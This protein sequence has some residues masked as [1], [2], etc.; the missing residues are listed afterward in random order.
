MAV[1]LVRTL[2]LRCTSNADEAAFT[3]LRD[4]ARLEVEP[5]RVIGGQMVS[6]HAHRHGLTLPRETVDA[7]LGLQPFVLK[8]SNIA[9]QLEVIGYRQESGCRF[10]RTLDHLASAAGPVEA[11]IDLLVPSTQTRARKSVQHGKFNTTEVPGLSLAFQRQPIKLPIEVTYLS[12]EVESFTLILPDEIASL[13]LKV[14]ARTTRVKD[15]DA[16]DVWRCLEICFIAG[17]RQPDFGPDHAEV[18]WILAEDFCPAG[19]GTEQIVAAR[20]LNDDQAA[21]FQNRLTALTR[22]ITG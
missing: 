11:A 3:A 22:S 10:V 14:L 8:S 18:I 12:G 13:A 5:V 2:P 16:V 17:V 1:S 21:L 7:D 4:V 6:L 19:S 20:N 15:T 9:E